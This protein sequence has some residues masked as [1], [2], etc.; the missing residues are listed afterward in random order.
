MKGANYIPQDN[1]LPRVTP[2]R[3][4]HIL[5]SAADAHM[6]MIRVW[7]GGIYE[8]DIFYDLCDEKGLLVWQDFMF[9]CA[10]YPG[11]DVFLENVAK[12]AEENIKRLRSHPS[13]ALWCGN[14][15]ILMKW[16]G[17]RNNANE[18]GNQIPLWN[19]AGDSLKIVNAYDQIFKNIL[20]NAVKSHGLG[21]PYW[22]SSPSPKGGDFED[23][24]TGEAHYWGVW[25][26]QEPFEA[27]RR[28]IGRFMTEYGFQSFPEL[29]TVKTFTPEDDW[30]IYSDVPGGSPAYSFQFVTDQCGTYSGE[31]DCFNREHTFPQS[32][33]NSG[34][35]MS[36]DVFHI[37]P[38]DAWVNQKRANWPY[39]PVN[40]PT[41]VDHTAGK[42]RPK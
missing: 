3:Y 10:M 28:N 31:G 4:E 19:N 21:I 9:S 36:T 42:T 5:Q 14:N 18:E 12:E 16:H 11:D 15:E 35:P 2:E 26:G 17:W 27:Y 30:D 32:W 22:E 23:W 6:N 20:P 34:M 38:A 24:K 33:F 7:G 25:W 39:A 13:M 8:N 41:A 1:F 29:K 37:Y 40:A